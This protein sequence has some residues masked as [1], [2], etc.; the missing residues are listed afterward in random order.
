MVQEQ[1]TSPE[2]HLSLDFRFTYT[3]CN[4]FS[5]QYKSVSL[6]IRNSIL[7]YITYSAFVYNPSFHRMSNV[8]SFGFGNVFLRVMRFSKPLYSVFTQLTVCLNVKW[9]KNNCWE[10]EINSPLKQCWNALSIP[11]AQGTAAPVRWKRFWS[12][13]RSVG[14][15]HRLSAHPC[16]DPCWIWIFLLH[17][18]GALETR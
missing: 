18:W 14:R 1:L 10:R 8:S 13:W 15:A 16:T 12:V 9:N 6:S 7:H 4:W 5:F 11:G 3:T 2:P 17:D